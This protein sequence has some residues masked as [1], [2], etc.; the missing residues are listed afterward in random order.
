MAAEVLMAASSG[1]DGWL[2]VADTS[3]GEASWRKD[4][5]FETAFNICGGHSSSF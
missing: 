2:P 1:C 5:F 3:A 4:Y